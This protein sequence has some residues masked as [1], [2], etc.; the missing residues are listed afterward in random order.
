MPSFVW[1]YNRLRTM[2]FPEL[3]YRV[4]KR[5]SVHVERL[6]RCSGHEVST[7]TSAMEEVDP[8]AA[9][10]LQQN[11]RRLFSWKNEKR[12]ALQPHGNGPEG[13]KLQNISREKFPLFDLHANLM[14]Q[15]V[16]WHRDPKTGR[17]WPLAHSDTINIRDAQSIGEVDY[18]WRLNRCQHIAEYAKRAY[19]IDDDLLKDVAVNQIKSWIEANPYKVGV[20]WTSPME[21]SIRC[22]SWVLGISFLIQD[23]DLPSDVASS[24]YHSLAKQMNYIFDNL[25]R[26]SSANNHL[27]AELTGLITLGIAFGELGDG[28]K[29]RERG[30]RELTQELNRQI[31]QDGVNKEQSTHYHSLV[32]DCL[33]WLI[34]LFRRAH[35]DI[36]NI[37]WTYSERMCDFLAAIMDTAGNIPGIGDSDDAWVIWV[38]DMS[39]LNNYRS[40]LATGAV[41]FNRADFKALAIDFDEKSLWLLGAEGY[42]AFETLRNTSAVRASRPFPDSGYYVL[43]SVRGETEKLLLFDCGPLGYP[44]TAAHG[45]AD[46]LSIWLSVGGHPVL[47]DSGTYSYLVHPEWRDYFRGTAAHNTV[48]VNGHDQSVAGG[49]YIWIKHAHARCD[50]WHTSSS[51]DYVMGTHE[52][53][54]RRDRVVHT[55]RILFVKPD[56]W[57]VED[58]FESANSFEGEAFFHFSEKGQA[59]LVRVDSYFL[60]QWRG[61]PPVGSLK[62]IFPFRNNIKARLGSADASAKQGWI[63]PSYGVK[64][65]SSFLAVK[66][67][68]SSKSR[69]TYL[70]APAATLQEKQLEETIGQ[71]PH[72]RVSSETGYDRYT[73]EAD[74]SI[75]D[76]FVLHDFGLTWALGELTI[77]AETICT[78][79]NKIGIIEKLFAV[80]PTEILWKGQPTASHLLQKPFLVIESTDPDQPALPL[81]ELELDERLENPFRTS[82]GVLMPDVAN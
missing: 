1:Y 6:R 8:T 55:R 41:L 62:I 25:S 3:I 79:C 44:A 46:A 71:P 26:Y 75:K 81:V 63:S 51:F 2:S 4:R 78:C 56:F 14:D 37:F 21:A 68:E 23:D 70:L 45:H 39:R 10:Q 73:Y 80:A 36:P 67:Q 5:T 17:H 7:G 54:L 32:L 77:R 27:I 29:W 12:L 65:P 11:M 31:W 19:L 35:L 16:D 61:E 9:Y 30:V 66:V 64:V 24:V 82:M 57:F 33:L 15:D 53:Y 42:K 74:Q 50:N 22:I 20:N 47:I 28:A 38:A 48:V 76:I 43:G 69:L 72:C 34:T 59:K 58:C 49:P 13:K 52:G 40:Q 18:I 60:C